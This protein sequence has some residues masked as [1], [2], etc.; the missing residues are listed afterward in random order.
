MRELGANDVRTF[1][2]PPRWLLD[3]AAEHGLRVLVG[4]P[5]GGARLL[6]RRRRGPCPRSAA[7]FARRR[8]QLGG[9]PALLGLLIGNEIPPDIVRW[10]GP[11]RVQEFLRVLAD[12][13]KAHRARGAGQLRQLPVDRVSRSS[14][15]LDFVS[16]NV[17]LHREDDFRRYLAACRTSRGTSRWC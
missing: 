3:R 8:A 13:V 6:P 17:Y 10:Y 7:R 9:H 15:F 16:F 2:V 4:H 14:T 1:T 12:E 11:E 5:V